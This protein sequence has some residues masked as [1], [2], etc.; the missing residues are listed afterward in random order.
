MKEELKQFEVTPE[1]ANMMETLHQKY[2]AYTKAKDLIL[3]SGDMEE[4]LLT[5]RMLLEHG[6]V[7]TKDPLKAVSA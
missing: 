5:V 6:V 1:C 3:E 7:M 2:P 4:T